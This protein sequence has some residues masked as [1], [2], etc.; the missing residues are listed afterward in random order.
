MATKDTLL[1][2]QVEH[3]LTDATLL[4]CLAA[5]RGRVTI[6]SWLHRLHEREHEFAQDHTHAA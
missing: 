5:T 6:G 3:A 4:Q 1:H 2:L